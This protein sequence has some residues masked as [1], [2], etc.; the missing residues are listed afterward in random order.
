[1]MRTKSSLKVM[2]LQNFCCLTCRCRRFGMA[3]LLFLLTLKQTSL[4]CLFFVWV[5]V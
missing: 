3:F 2:N 1:M 5:F 4:A